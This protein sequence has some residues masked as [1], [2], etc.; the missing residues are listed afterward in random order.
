MDAFDIML[1]LETYWNF[2]QVVYDIFSY[3]RSNSS[4]YY[5]IYVLIIYVELRYGIDDS[6]ILWIGSIFDSIDIG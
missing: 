6:S 2:N 4:E 1:V 3:R 5:I